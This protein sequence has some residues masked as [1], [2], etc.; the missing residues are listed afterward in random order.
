[1][2]PRFST[3]SL[4]RPS[5]NGKTWVVSEGFCVLGYF[6]T[7]KEAKVEFDRQRRIAANE[8]EGRRAPGE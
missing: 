2:E 4:G 7:R 1:M 8:L 5:I 3:I 6:K